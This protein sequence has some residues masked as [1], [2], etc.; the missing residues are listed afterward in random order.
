MSVRVSLVVA[1]IALAVT[2]SPTSAEFVVPDGSNFA[3]TRGVTQ[4]SLYT[5]WNVF[6]STAGPNSPDVGSYIGGSLPPRAPAFNAF[7]ADWASSGSFITGGGNIYSIAGIISPHIE[8][9]GFDLGS[10]YNTTVLMQLRTQGTEFNPATVSLNGA[11]APIETTELYREPL[12]GFGGFIV[13]TLFRFEVTG[14]LDSY[15]ITF[16]ATEG[17]MSLDRIA[18][19]T[20]TSIA[21]APCPADMVDSR[22]FQPPPDGVVDGAD[23]AFLLGAWGS[24]PGSPADIVNSDTFQPPPDGVV[25]GADLA[26]LLGA[27][28]ECN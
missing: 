24:N 17:S 1:G 10:A 27:W 14:N 9:G 18:I 16:D 6:T 2:N 25:D 15:V 12:G 26:V 19:D 11:I 8:F 23:L 13:D 5:E 28:G 20:F 3:W 21:S 7:D 22:T 4:L